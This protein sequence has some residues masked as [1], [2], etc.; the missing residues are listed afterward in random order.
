[1]WRIA[2]PGAHRKPIDR[3]GYRGVWRIHRQPSPLGVKIGCGG[4]RLHRQRYESVRS[5]K[6]VVLQWWFVYLTGEQRF[7]LAIGGNGIEMLGPLSESR[8]KYR[9][10]AIGRWIRCVPWLGRT[11]I[12][13][14]TAHPKD[15]PKRPDTTYEAS[16]DSR[17]QRVFAFLRLRASHTRLGARGHALARCRTEYRAAL[18]TLS[19]CQQ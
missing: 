16:P 9:T 6:K 10:R 13:R 19:A 2:N 17:S 8:K 4:N 1:M 12:L 7:I 15:T 3:A 18:Y 14:H 11:N 5:F